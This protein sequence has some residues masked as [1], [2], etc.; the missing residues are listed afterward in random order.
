MASSYPA[1]TCSYELDDRLII[2]NLGPGWDE[3]AAENGARDLISPA[4]LGRPLLMFL[5]DATTVHLYEQLFHRVLTAKRAITFPIRCDAPA[6]RRYLDLTISL[7]PRGGFL[8]SSV[9]VRSEPRAPIGLL[10][11][12]VSRGDGMVAMCSW[13][14]RVHATGR[15]LEVEE[16]VARLGLFER[17][18][19]PLVTHGICDAC[20]RFMV[21]MLADDLELP[22]L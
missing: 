3:F 17:R 19:Q 22:L 4:P 15:W 9:L 7:T 21:A 8:V 20:Q 12:H 2:R 6:L 18:Q 10:A 13:C 1:V 5:T 14:K 11:T 16:A